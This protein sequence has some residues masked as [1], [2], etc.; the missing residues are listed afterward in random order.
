M[1]CRSITA[2][3]FEYL[4]PVMEILPVQLASTPFLS[5]RSFHLLS[6]PEG[7]NNQVSSLMKLR[8][9]AGIER[10]P[11]I[12]WEPRPS[13][14]TPSNLNAFLSAIKRVDVFSPNHIELA[15]IFGASFTKTQG[16]TVIEKHALDFIEAGIGPS[17]DGSVV[18]R[19]GE[20]GCMVGSR[21]HAIEWI[22]PFYQPGEDGVNSRVV[23]PT[24][25]GNAFLGSFAVGY[26][27]TGSLIHASHFGNVGA[28]FVVE[29]VGVPLLETSANGKE[30]WNGVEVFE[31]LRE[32]KAQLG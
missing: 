16:R 6:S 9:Q 13:S 26:L 15:Q 23:D 3:T 12:L 32:Y 8:Q 10:R 30:S 17:K 1:L 18:V 29:Q 20:G 24:G 21:T 5:S 22:E 27:Q 4:T 2:K 19:A 14:C 11:F 25:A 28:S 7:L 31:R